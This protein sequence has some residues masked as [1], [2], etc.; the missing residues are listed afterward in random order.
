M[1]K[2]LHDVEDSEYCINGAKHAP[3]DG[4]KEH[5]TLRAVEELKREHADE[6]SR[7]W[8]KVEDFEDKFARLERKE[9]K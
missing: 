2:P 5:W 3:L 9:G 7:L 8:D 1:K 4:P 6:I